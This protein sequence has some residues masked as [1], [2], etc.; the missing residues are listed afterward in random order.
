MTNNESYHDLL[1]DWIVKK[2]NEEKEAKN[3]QDLNES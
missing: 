3:S 1:S 2:E